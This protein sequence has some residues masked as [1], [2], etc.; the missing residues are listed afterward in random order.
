MDHRFYTFVA[1]ETGQWSITSVHP[2][3]GQ[4]LETAPRLDIQSSQVLA[5]PVSSRW[6][7]R[8][9]TSNQRYVTRPEQASLVAIQAG[10]GRAEATCAALIPITKTAGWWTLTQDERREIFEERSSHIGIGLR[11]LPAI[12]RKLYHSR[13]LGEPFDFLTWFE[14]APADA[15]AFDD[16]VAALR[17]TEE[18][19]YVEREVDVRLIRDG[20]NAPDGVPE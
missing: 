17:V 8:G 19:K 20:K 4:P 9:V 2:V 15:T 1:G 10:L 16:L 11:Y 13:D 3:I 5:S 7:L 12:A 14:F 18:W 6:L